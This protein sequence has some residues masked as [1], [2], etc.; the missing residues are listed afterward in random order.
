VTGKIP[1]VEDCNEML[2]IKENVLLKTSTFSDTTPCSP[3]ED[4]RRFGSRKI[5]KQ[6]TSMK[7]TASRLEDEGEMF[8][9]NVD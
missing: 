5:A 3:L 6:E 8:L 7:L 2:Q 1:D 4:S 9:R